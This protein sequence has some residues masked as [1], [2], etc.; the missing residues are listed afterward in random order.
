MKNKSIRVIALFLGVCLIAVMLCGCDALD[1]KKAHL[2]HWTDET[3][4]AFTLDGVTYRQLKM[5][6]TVDFVPSAQA[7]EETLAVSQPDV[8]VLAAD[9]FGTTLYGV[10]DGVWER[11]DDD[12]NMGSVYYCREDLFETCRKALTASLDHL[13]YSYLEFDEDGMFE[14]KF[15]LVKQSVLDGITQALAADPLAFSFVGNQEENRAD[16]FVC[17]ASMTVYGAVGVSVLLTQM[18]GQPTY[19]L[20]FSGQLFEIPEELLPDLTAIYETVTKETEELLF[21]D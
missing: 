1:E 20:Q 5:N 2:A 18:N 13:C 4:T 17:D 15:T 14:Q 11:Y 21:E 12:G 8:P 6:D 3:E 10:R 16:L 19:L 9:F 7:E